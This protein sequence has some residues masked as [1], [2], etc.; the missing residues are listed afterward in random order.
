MAAASGG[1]P[2]EILDKIG[3]H[4]LSC[5]ICLEQYVVPKILPCHHTFCLHCLE[6]LVKKKGVLNCPT[7]QQEVDLK[8]GGV[9]A[10]KNNFF[11]N[12]LLDVVE[13]RTEEAKKTQHKCELICEENEATHFCRDCEQYFCNDCLNLVHKKLK[14]ASSHTVLSVEE[15]EKT[16]FAMQSAILSVERCKGHPANEVKFFCDTCQVPICSDCT[17]IEHPNTSHSYRYLQDVAEEYTKELS[18]MVEKLREKAK[19]ADES[20]TKAVDVCKKVKNQFEVEERKV[21]QQTEMSTNAIKT[22]IKRNIKE[23]E[24]QIDMLETNA[25]EQIDMIEEQQ[26]TLI[27]G[28]K[29]DCHLQV[30][31]LETQIADLEFKSENIISTSGYVKALVNHGSAAQLVSSKA[32]IVQ[33]IEELVAME[34]KPGVKQEVVTF[35]PSSDITTDGILGVLRYDVC[36]SLCTVENIPKRLVKGESVK[37]LITTK[38]NRGK[39]VIPNQEVK[40]KV[41]KPDGSQEDIPVTD[42]KDGTHSVLIHGEMDGK[43]QVTMV[44]GDQPIPGS[45]LVLPVIKG[46][47]KTI[48]KEGSNEGDFNL[49]FSV[50]L[51]RHG[52]MVVADTNNQRMQVIDIH[53]KCKKVLKFTQF[54]ENFRPRD[55]AISADD[56]YFMTDYWNKQ[57]V[58]SDEDGNVIRCFGQNELKYPLGVCIGPLDGTVYVTDW[59]GEFGDDTDKEGS[60]CIR[61]YRQNGDY[62]NSFGKYGDENGEFKGPYYMYIDSQGILYVT[63]CDNDCVQVFNADDQFLYKFGIA[64]QSEGQLFG[65]SGIVMDKDRYLYVSDCEHRV[66]KFDMSGRFICRIDRD[67][68]RLNIPTGLVLTNDVP[69]KLVVVDWNNHCLKVFVL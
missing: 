57:I 62:I 44:I 10:L 36:P 6:T 59:D 9:A 24:S 43:Y 8:S 29:T 52:D 49:P 16:K 12:T 4:C 42:N 64:G 28:L 45:P 40:V 30:K 39:T 2:E 17:V 55:I 25:K 33:R 46:L 54:K 13:K 31:Q 3:E 7:C 14:R 1:T 19:E 63:D 35:K 56:E 61:K 41:R 67:E 26:C 15:H 66:Q 20:K 5:S 65:P 27:E 18:E 51:N 60:H 37:L 58:D 11:M 68:D 69:V 50:T 32:T 21:N 38:D 22:T 47:V 23:L 53:G 34:T 48:G